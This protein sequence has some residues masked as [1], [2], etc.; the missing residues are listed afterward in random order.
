VYVHVVEFNLGFGVIKVP[1]GRVKGSF[2]LCSALLCSVLSLYP[3]ISSPN[4]GQVPTYTVMSNIVRMRG[5]YYAGEPKVRSNIPIITA[6]S[7]F[8]FQFQFQFP[9]S[10]Y[11][12]HACDTERESRETSV[13]GKQIT[14]G[15][16][17]TFSREEERES[18][19][20]GG[21]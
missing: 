2:A 6:Q 12:M 20:P 14:M 1:Q 18:A 11:T 8:Q 21:N 13:T 10:R 16:V 7:Q 15:R 17:P 4:F 9:P 3:D 5:G 19:R